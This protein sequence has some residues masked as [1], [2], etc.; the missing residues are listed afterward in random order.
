MGSPHVA[1]R[2]GE[3]MTSI[4]MRRRRM[5]GIVAVLCLLCAGGWWCYNR[6]FSE[7]ANPSMEEYPVRGI[8]VSAHNGEIDFQR[9][10]ESGVQFAYIKA[11]EG[12]D[13]C[14]RRFHIN[15]TGMARAG[16]PAG[17]YHFFRFDRDGEMQ[18]WN[19]IHSLEGRDFLLPP[20]VDVEEW[21]NPDGIHSARVRKELRRM[22]ELLRREGYDPVVYSNKKGY[23]RYIRDNFSDFPLWICSFTDPPVGDDPWVIWQYSHRGNISG[24]DGPVDCNTICPAHPLA[25]AVTGYIK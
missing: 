23:H 11:T 6:Y 24:I 10:R 17:A 22:L 1:E 21:G 20:A 25:S 12:A 15:A 16:I 19:F 5:I 7:R 2:K 18:A 9:L 8:D 14:D 13:F 4:G 3:E